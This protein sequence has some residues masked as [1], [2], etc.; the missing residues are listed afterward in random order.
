M[1]VT[2]Y[3][4][5]VNDAALYWPKRGSNESTRRNLRQ[6]LFIHNAN[7]EQYLS[8]RTVQLIIFFILAAHIRDPPDAPI[9][10]HTHARMDLRYKTI[11]RYANRISCPLIV[12]RSFALPRN[13]HPAETRDHQQTGGFYWGCWG[14]VRAIDHTWTIRKVIEFSG[15]WLNQYFCVLWLSSKTKFTNEMVGGMMRDG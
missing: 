14:C 2:C 6:I 7:I 15:D 11:R 3:K 12:R 4:L 9:Y 5:N 8:K 13:T 1:Q 10:T